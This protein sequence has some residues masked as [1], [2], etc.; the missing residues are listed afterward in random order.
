[1]VKAGNKT[2]LVQCPCCGPETSWENVPN[3][4]ARWAE[5][6]S[7]WVVQC[8]RCRLSTTAFVLQA[9]AAAQWNRRYHTIESLVTTPAVKALYVALNSRGCDCGV[10]DDC[11]AL[12]PFRKYFLNE[13]VSNP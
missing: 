3:F 4:A 9:D 5:G 2:M 12:E 6:M 7:G 1:M 8:G 11:K 13:P 10:C